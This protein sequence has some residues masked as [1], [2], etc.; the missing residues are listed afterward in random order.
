MSTLTTDLRA[1][2]AARSR[3]ERLADGVIAGYLHSLFQASTRPVAATPARR[4]S[5]SARRLSGLQ[6][7]RTRGQRRGC[8]AAVASAEAL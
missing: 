4:I 7:Q 6:Q 1:P 5:I 3:S 2:T 8:Q